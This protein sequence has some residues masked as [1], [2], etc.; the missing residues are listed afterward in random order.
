MLEFEIALLAILII[1]SAFFSGSETALMSLNMI[2]VR[3]LAKRKKRGSKSLLKLKQNPR[4]LLITLLIGNNLVNIGAAAL[5]TYV[6]T[7][8]FWWLHTRLF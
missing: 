2:K 6:F 7:R 8:L 5:A 4:R 3:S 1:L